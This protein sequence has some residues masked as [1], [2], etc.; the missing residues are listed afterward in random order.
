MKLKTLLKD[1]KVIKE[2]IKKIEITDIAISTDMVKAGSLFVCLKGKKYDGHNFKEKAKKQGAVCF[3]VEEFDESFD[4]VQILV[5]NT[6]EALPI[7]AKNFY[8][9]KKSLKI[10][11]ITGT[12]G[13]TTSTFL[14]ANILKCAGKKVGV[15]G[16]EGVFFNNIKISHNMTTPDPIELFKYLSLMS[17][18]NIDYVVMEVSAHAIYYNKIKGINFCAKA[19]SNITPDHLDFFDNMED[20]SKQ[21]I[22]FLQDGKNIKVANIDDEYCLNLSSKNKNIYTF[23]KEEGADVF[24]YDFSKDFSEFCINIFNKQISVKTNLIGNF[25]VENVLLASTIA[26]LLGIKLDYIKK[27]I[28]IFKSVDGRMN[29]YKNGEKTVIIDFAHTPDAM[30]KLLKTIR[31]F[32]NKKLYTIFGCGGERD[33]KKRT[34]MGEIASNFCD[35]VVISNDNPRSEDPMDI[36][37]QIASGIKKGNFEIIL[38]RKK[39]IKKVIN[40]MSDGDI[41]A[42]LGKG[43]EDYI[44]IGGIKYPYSDKEEVLKW[45]FKD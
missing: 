6:R 24:A 18:A 2:N 8:K 36:A 22:N 5:N 37:N 23:S 19:I 30:E 33:A 31:Q 12:N 44:E 16:T 1:I 25:N 27:G 40:S 17:K 7:L 21:K 28:E 42:L 39:A 29:V 3:L 10:I 32:T 41:L 13:K 9:P 15:I 4:G 43:T 38:D 26:N 45:G 34:V 11:G 35:S 20:Y 14:L